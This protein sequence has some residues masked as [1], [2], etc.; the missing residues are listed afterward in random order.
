MR[1]MFLVCYDICNDRRRSEVYTTMRGF[2]EHI[3]LSV[4]RCELSSREYAEMISEL[5]PLIDHDV[6]QILVVDIGPIDGRG[7]QVFEAL[8]RPYVP[9]TRSAIVI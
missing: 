7:S 5:G 2:G 3:Q 4:F 6:D 1:N 8:G 9:A